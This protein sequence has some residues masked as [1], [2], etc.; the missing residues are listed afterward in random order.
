MRAYGCWHDVLM[1]QGG[2]AVKA[3]VLS[4]APMRGKEG[5]SRSPCPVLPCPALLVVLLLVLLLLLPCRHSVCGTAFPN[6]SPPPPS[7]P[8]CG[9]AARDTIHHAWA[10][11]S[12]MRTSCWRHHQ[13][14]VCLS[15]VC[16]LHA[17]PAG[18]H[19][20]TMCGL[21]ARDDVR[22]EARAQGRSP[23]GI[24]M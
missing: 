18:L 13:R 1:H 16:L 14:C 4:S 17:W 20:E 23:P 10:S 3:A 19:S 7:S 2:G 8:L 15:G 5:A 21:A 6:T 22:Q 12:C 9:L 24:G 11:V